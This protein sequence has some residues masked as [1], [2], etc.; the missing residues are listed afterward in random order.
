MYINTVL[1]NRFA[2]ESLVTTQLSKTLAV[3]AGAI[4]FLN[5][6]LGWGLG[7]EFL[8]RVLPEYPAMV[9]ETALAVLF[10]A[11]GVFGNS[12]SPAGQ[13]IRANSLICAAAIYLL[14]AQSRLMPL[15]HSDMLSDDEMSV[16][17]L[18]CCGTVAT[19]LLLSTVELQWVRRLKFSLLSIG[20]CVCALPLLGYLFNAT[21][22][23]SDENF[24]SM[25]IHTAISFELLLFAHLLKFKKFGWLRILL[26]S[27]RGSVM[28]RR[29]LPILVI[30]PLVFCG[31]ALAIGL[32]SSISLN[33]KLAGLAFFMILFTS[34][35][36]IYF[37]DR[38]NTLEN[39]AAAAERMV[40]A[41]ERKKVVTDSAVARAQK[42]TAL[43]QLV[44]GVAHDFNNTMTVILGNLELIETSD[45]DSRQRS[46]LK[47]AINASNHAVHVTRQLLAYGR[48]SRL[49]AH[50][51]EI[52]KLV[53][54]F[55][56]TLYI[57]RV[58]NVILETDLESPGAHVR[59]DEAHFNQC[60]VNLFNNA[61]DAMPEGGV[62]AIATHVVHLIGKEVTGFGGS[63]TLADGNYV[64]VSI[65]DD[66]KGMS[67]EVLRQATEP[68]FTTKPVGKGDGLGLSVASGFCRQC[69][70]GL[71]LQS[72]VGSGTVATMLFPLIPRPKPDHA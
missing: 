56:T 62:V 6:L 63:E 65:A 45:L 67:E 61:C 41:S 36:S 16:F 68:F 66:G 32:N 13:A 21:I 47:Q 39:R 28:L 72:T 7:V 2:W 64:A 30:V 22:L 20:I 15:L 1:K 46:E 43:S 50:L 57:L 37:A 60:F 10:G 25:A 17:T 40:L 26:S 58:S 29:I 27:E 48:K 70:G 9:P 34:A 69:G 31:A 33:L 49:D 19:C 59:I 23:F 71:D 11:I 3:I 18:I 53:G 54:S 51:V 24:T 8:V 55:L 38:V 42:M 44:G 35:A 12:F 14:M 5:L 4:A 52:D